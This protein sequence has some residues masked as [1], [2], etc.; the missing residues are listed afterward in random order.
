VT[1][2]T[3][4]LTT[5][6]TTIVLARVLV[7]ADFGVL[8]LAVLA[9]GAFAAVGE[10]GLGSTLVLRQDFDRRAQGTVLSMMLVTGTAAAAVLAGG[11]PVM[12]ALFGESRLAGMLA[13]LAFT[14][15]LNAVCSFYESILLR[16]LEF[17]KRFAT[18]GA[19]SAAYA[20][21]ALGLA[22]LGAG[23]WSLAVAHVVATAAR[24]AALLSVSPYRVRPAFDPGVARDA[25]STGRSFL[26][27]GTIAFFR[28]NTDYLAVGRVLGARPL[29]FYSMGYRLA[30]LPAWAVA[31][32]IARV[33]FPSF[34]RMRSRGEDVGDTFLAVLQLVGLVTVPLGLALSAASAPFTAALFGPDWAPMVGPL[35]VLGL[36]GAIRPVQVTLGWF[37]NSIGEAGRSARASAVTLAVLIPSGLLAADHGGTVA[38]AWV[39]VTEAAVSGCVFALLAHGRGGLR[40]ALQWQALR[41]LAIAAPVSWT[42]GRLVA[43]ALESMSPVVGVVAASGMVLI[44][45]GG[46]LAATGPE[47]LRGAVRQGRRIRGPAVV[48]SAGAASPS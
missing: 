19:Q 15:V 11:A 29:G 48:A 25:L 12:A 38:V 16:E 33:T 5:V 18:Y 30:E 7:P 41:P 35:T 26:A 45:F 34:A 3:T 17:R 9:T 44:V 13:V 47:V 24:A 23:I 43:E 28:Q 21:T 32:P 2:A 37:L 40:I 46:V 20:V 6:V 10:L 39:M 36:W 22:G 4:R 8:A 1:Y 42:A 27:Q 31:D 14:L